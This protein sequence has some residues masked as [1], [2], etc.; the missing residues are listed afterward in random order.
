MKHEPNRKLILQSI[1]GTWL[2][3][4][5][6]FIAFLPTYIV[7]VIRVRFTQN[8]ISSIT[9]NQ[10][11]ET[12]ATYIVLFVL[13]Y[14]ILFLVSPITGIISSHIR[15]GITNN[16]Y[17][18]IF[19]S[20]AA[21]DLKELD[22]VDYLV[23]IKRACMTADSIIYSQIES[24]IKFGT[25]IVSFAYLLCLIKEINLVYIALFT[26]MAIIQNVY[27]WKMTKETIQLSKYVDRAGR[28]HDYFLSL[29]QS[30]EYA[31][32][33]RSYKLH[34][35]LERKRHDAYRDKSNE[36][37]KLN[38]KWALKS[39]VWSAVMYLLEGINIVYSFYLYSN[40]YITISKFISLVQIQIQF[41]STV[42]L[43]F[44][45]LSTLKQNKAY[46]D[47][48]RF[49]IQSVHA[50]QS[51]AEW[52]AQTGHSE[53]VAEVRGLSYSYREGNTVLEDITLNIRRGESI[54]ILGENG[55]GKSTLA[56]ILCSLL[57]SYTGSL[58]VYDKNVSAVFQDYAKFSFTLKENIGFGNIERIDD[59]T[60][61]EKVLIKC[62][63][64]KHL[65]TLPNG[66]HTYMGKE[67][68]KNGTDI[69]TGQWQK[70]SIG[71]GLYADA[72]LIIF[73]EPT[74]ALDPIAEYEQFKFIKECL[75]DKTT[76]LISHRIGLTKLV[77][78][79]VF[80]KDGR[81][82]EYGTHND[83][84]AKK[85]VYYNFYNCQA[86]WYE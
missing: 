70:V 67:F 34:D 42:G 54:A 9:D 69:S 21:A 63:M 41:L 6:L 20:V 53:N 73:D 11:Y 71:R 5:F 1:R 51:E 17:S 33:I 10:S 50:Q 68:L 43:C 32:E 25:S 40:N 65:E 31:K 24:I 19:K 62:G 77:D 58:I 27:I 8:I 60:A 48:Y 80:L 7:P 28:K 35:W 57:K 76:V 14:I 29:L 26:V 16:A 59:T 66:I 49:I 56:K 30:R 13:S 83:L 72:D 81:I 39:G 22:N 52:D 2:L 46:F 37:L 18:R 64:G 3:V 79:I 44:S 78:K 75:S 85:G 15:Y 55:S 45:I 86:Q 82:I 61:I 12:V 36:H 23:K 84:M 4:V 47:D 74:A 38:K